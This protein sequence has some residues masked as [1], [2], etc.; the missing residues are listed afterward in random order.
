MWVPRA[1]LVYYVIE[2]TSSRQQA[3]LGVFFDG[4]I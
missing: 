2:S 1:G 3:P 4:A